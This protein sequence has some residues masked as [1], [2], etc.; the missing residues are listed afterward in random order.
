M[1]DE[2]ARLFTVRVVARISDPEEMRSS[3]DDDDDEGG[4]DKED[5]EDVD[6][7][8]IEEKKDAS[9]KQP[10]YNIGVET[11]TDKVEQVEHSVETLDSRMA[12]SNIDASTEKPIK[13]VIETLTVDNL[14][15]QIEKQAEKLTESQVAKSN[16][17][18]QNIEQEKTS[19]YESYIA[20]VNDPLISAENDPIVAVLSEQQEHE[21]LDYVEEQDTVHISM[22]VNQLGQEKEDNDDEVFNFIT[23]EL[24]SFYDQDEEVMHT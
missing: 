3:F 15:K 2:F 18:Q 5:D 9:T 22:P 23:T 1:T 7:E 20:S 13:T 10:T 11:Q 6:K 8:S 14:E 21:V 4:G 17:Q 16:G 24:P 12:T 19:Q